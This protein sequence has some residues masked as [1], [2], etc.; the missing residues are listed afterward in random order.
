MLL[1]DFYSLVDIRRFLMT[2]IS[3][4]FF[5]LTSGKNFR[6]GWSE[7]ATV[8]LVIIQELISVPPGP[9]KKECISPNFAPSTSKIK[10][11]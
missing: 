2:A 7:L 9:C 8:F 10:V 11:F 1:S 3:V 4:H 5:T 6:G